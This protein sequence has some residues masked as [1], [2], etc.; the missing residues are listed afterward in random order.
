[1]ENCCCIWYD[2]T[3][4]SLST[5]T[6]TDF[7]CPWTNVLFGKYS[8][9][10]A[11]SLLKVPRLNHLVRAEVLSFC[12][13]FFSCGNTIW[14]FLKKK[15]KINTLLRSSAD[16]NCQHGPYLWYNSVA[17]FKL[18]SG[19]ILSRRRPESPHA[20]PSSISRRSVMASERQSPHPN[21]PITTES[22]RFISEESVNRN[23]RIGWRSSL[24]GCGVHRRRRQTGQLIRAKHFHICLPDQLCSVSLPGVFKC[25]VL[26][27]LPLTRDDLLSSGG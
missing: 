23:E 10:N 16:G 9:F 3:V 25:G 24:L 15:K 26:P 21:R 1:M 8:H 22:W 2:V 19:S 5:L 11:M 7:Q 6:T 18:T 12:F 20:A 27:L 4:P 14:I 17:I 13:L